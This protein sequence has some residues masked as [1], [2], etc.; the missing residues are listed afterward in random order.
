M[1]VNR[2]PQLAKSE[3]I[4]Q[5]PL[6][7]QHEDA[8]VEFLE[9][10]R[11]GDSPCCVWCGSTNVY[12][13]MDAATGARNKRY[14]W[15]C[16]D[17]KK[18]YTV[19]IGTV[20]EESRIE[21]R[22]WCYAFW[23]A[24]TSKKGVAALEI[25]R[26]CQISYKAA[27]FLMHRIRWAM[28]PD[29]KTAPKLKGVVEADETYVGGKPRPMQG[30]EKRKWNTN[31]TPVFAVVQRGGDI[32]VRTMTA[33]KG[34]NVREALTEL[35]DP[36]SRLMTDENLVYR[37]IGREFKGGHET[38]NHSI[39]EYAREDVTTNTV[40]GFFATLKRGLNGIYHAVSKEHLHRYCAEFEFRYNARKMNDGDRTVLAI[41]SAEG[42]RLMYKSPAGC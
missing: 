13:M 9:Q 15:R 2:Q 40:E 25:M 14:L 1:K 11:W 19:R 6:A 10:Q 18:Q 35:V 37:P 3:V 34:A 29:H 39:D 23:R 24:A 31:K 21:L 36:K 41:Q 12:K 22:H 7:C 4:R 5:I 38:V 27:L 17:C 33:V 30:F 26:Q 20:Y 42:K 32:R 28:A 16:R 8:A